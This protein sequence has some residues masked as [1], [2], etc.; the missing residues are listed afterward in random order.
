MSQRQCLPLNDEEDSLSSSGDEEDFDLNQITALRYLKSVRKERERIPEIVTTKIPAEF[1]T[2]E[3]SA[4]SQ[5]EKVQH[6][7]DPTKEWQ[8]IQMERFESLQTRIV[9]MRSDPAL[10]EKI[11]QQLPIDP[12]NEDEEEENVIKYCETNEPLLSVLLAMNQGHLEQLIEILTNY[13]TE[14]AEN[15]N[16][17][18]AIQR[19]SDSSWVCMWIFSTLACLATPLVPEVHN[20]LRLIAK[21][22]ILVTNHLKSLTDTPNSLIFLPYNLLLVV[23]A[24]NFHQFDLMNL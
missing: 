21:A 16:F 3:I 13:L 17:L 4:D 2:E 23:I 7:T 18:E 20:T 11:V 9:Q 5:K 15:P 6:D 8:Q 10:S 24:R 22:C 12:C 19:S 1:E 14:N